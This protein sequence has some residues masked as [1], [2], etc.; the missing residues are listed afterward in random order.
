MRIALISAVGRNPYAPVIAKR[1]FDIGHAL[2][3]R[4]ATMMIHNI[5]SHIADNQT[6]RDL[7]DVKRFICEGGDRAAVGARFSASSAG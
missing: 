5:A 7:N 4:S 3:H 6:E 1:E 2:A